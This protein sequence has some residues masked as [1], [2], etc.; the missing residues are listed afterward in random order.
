MRVNQPITGREVPLPEG[1]M[2]VSRT[3]AGGRI[4]FC[5]AAFVQ[6]SGFS[7]EELSGAPHNIV[8]HPHM[9][10]AAFADLWATAKAGRPWEGLVKNRTK[11][12]DFYWVRANVTPVLE[13]G[14]VTGYVSIRT[15]PTRAEVAAAEAA[16]AALREGRGRRIGLRDGAL[17]PAGKRARLARAAASVTGRLGLAAAAAVLGG[18]AA[19]GRLALA[20]HLGQLAGQGLNVQP[21]GE[22]CAPRAGWCGVAHLARGGEV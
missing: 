14:Q 10:P 7:M 2:L 12:G 8:R 19:L 22:G 20:R 16:Y 17:V 6:V 3:D 13:A 5:N 18:A 9:P 11:S 4:A 15:A 1:E 21:R